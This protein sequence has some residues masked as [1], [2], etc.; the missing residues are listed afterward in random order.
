MG[1]IDSAPT[2]ADERT[3]LDASSL[4]QPDIQLK[5]YLIKIK[6]F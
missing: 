6:N 3:D 1:K 5:K 4:W 2:I